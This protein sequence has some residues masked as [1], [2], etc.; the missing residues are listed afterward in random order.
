MTCT[1]FL[2]IGT[3][4]NNKIGIIM[5]IIINMNEYL[6]NQYNILKVK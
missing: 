4:I 3:I 5:N 6:K 1:L 2:N